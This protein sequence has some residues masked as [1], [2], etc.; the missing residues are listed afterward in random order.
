VRDS[1]DG[2]L[3]RVKLTRQGKAR[4]D[5]LSTVHLHEL[6]NLAP[7]LDQ[8]ALDASADASPVATGAGKRRG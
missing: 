6:Q 2:R 7:V 5:R 3:V 1:S 8:L 4:I